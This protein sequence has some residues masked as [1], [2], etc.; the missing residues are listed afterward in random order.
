MY[1]RNLRSEKLIFWI[2]TIAYI[3]YG[4]IFVFKSSIMAGGE[5]YFVLF[6]DAMISMRY[7]RN[8]A[9]GYG[10]VWNPGGERIEGYTNPL[11]VLYMAL[12][13]L[14]PIRISITSL[15]IQLSGLIF[16]LANLFVIR[17][18]ALFL[19]PSAIG[20]ILTVL[21][22]AFYAPLS[23]WSL[24]GMEV[25]LLVLMVSTAVLLVFKSSQSERFD[26]LPYL[27]LGISTLI[28]MDMAVLY[29]V[30]FGFL[31][32]TNP[33]ERKRHLLWGAGILFVFVVIQ[34][35]FRLWYYQDFFPNTY[36]LK[37]EGYPI[38]A[39]LA[40]GL[41]VFFLFSWKLN[42]ILFLLP[43]S[44]FLFRRDR[45]TVF[46]F[47]IV[48]I[49]IAY[50]IYVGGDAWE[51]KGGSNRY[52]TIVMPIYFTLFVYALDL[53]REAVINSVG[54]ENQRIDF[55]A[56]AGMVILSLVALVNFNTLVDF[57]SLGRWVFTQTPD[58]IRGNEEYVRTALEIKRITSPDATIAVVSAGVIPYFTDRFAI[59][60]LGKNDPMIAHSPPRYLGEITNLELFRPG[61]M[62]WDYDYSIGEL[63]PDVIVQLWRDK[64]EAVPYLKSYYV[65]GRPSDSK[66]R[67]YYLRTGSPNILWDEV[68]IKQ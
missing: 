28:R 50:S 14:L 22:T 56:S 46:L 31:V 55:F 5:R 10:L 41:Y 20:A 3:L 59:D 16:L 66:G 68:E 21:I 49:Q 2:I 54:R 37:L 23:S 62:K 13:H 15:F 35:S 42:W 24:L 29:L 61:H 58:F 25:S 4:C 36:Y 9:Q 17:R 11:W 45:F 27:I 52:I 26:L 38:Y 57:K 8:L 34:M 7:A 64:D 40:H 48:F 65:T 19:S 53:M 6:D 63:A 12:F 43:F 30:V 32:F 44:I 60:L 33:K 47:L 18:I 39:R 1:L 67:Y 51:H